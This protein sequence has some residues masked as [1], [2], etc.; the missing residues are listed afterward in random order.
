MRPRIAVGVAAAIALSCLTPALTAATATAADQTTASH[1]HHLVHGMGLNLKE[2]RA[3]QANAV[4]AGHAQAVFQRSG[5][6]PASADLSKYA[7]SPGD[8]GQVGAC[9]AWATGYSAY[10]I[11]MNEQGISGA[12]MA[13]MYIYAQIAKGDDEGTTAS[14]ALPMERKQGIDTQSDYW[15]GTSDYTTQPDANERANAAHY[16]LSG[17]NTLPTS[18]SSARS[19]IENAISQGEPVVIGFQVHQSFEDLN[20]QTASDY[21][22]LPGDS[23]SDPILGGHEV[24]IVGYNSQGVKI[25]NSWGTS[26]GDGGFFTVPW[27]FFNTGD[28]MEVHSVGKLSTQG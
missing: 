14:V 28:I 22:Y 4:T 23:S 1:A 15:Q 16:K 18:G 24:T 6:A 19:G 13:P 9:V 11:V 2:V 26:W 21:S 8:Q 7:L 25:E 12:P 27:D 5:A 20:S 17:F 10:G 3:E